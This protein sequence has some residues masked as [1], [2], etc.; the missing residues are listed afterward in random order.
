MQTMNNNSILDRTVQPAVNDIAMPGY[1]EYT[2]SVLP[3]G[4]Q[5]HSLKGGTQP[6]TKIDIVNKA[7][8]RFADK[9]CVASMVNALAAEGTQSYTSKQ[10]ADLFDF[11]AAYIGQKSDGVNSIM[12]VA[13]MTKHLHRVLPVLEEI[14]KCAAFNQHEFDTYV[15]KMLQEHAVNMQTPSIVARRNLRKLIYAPNSRFCRLA[16]EEAYRSLTTADMHAFY[17]KTYTPE[18]AHIFVSGQPTDEDI[19]L[20][21]QTFSDQWKPNANLGEPELPT[22]ND[23]PQRMFAEMPQ[24]HQV[25]ICMGRSIFTQDHEDSLPMSVLDTIFGG[26][27]G[28]RL[29]Q[30][31]RE[32]KGLTYGIG[33]NLN[34]T[35]HA[36]LHTIGSDVHPD[37]AEQVIEEIGNEMRKLRTELVSTEELD[38]VRNYMKGILLRQFDSVLAS[39]DTLANLIIKGRSSDRIRQLYDV[40]NSVT[41]QQLLE[42]AN[43][44]Y[45]PDLYSISMA[46][47]R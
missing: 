12:T 11:C 28:S 4:I 33:S 27:F 29:M 37:K 15:D 32:E 6:I 3:N 43:K 2:N 30:N 10:V 39:A 23:A 8:A 26:Y 22:Y 36:G 45:L 7:G 38:T 19:D 5:F 13:V 31:I 35:K 42:L 41:P 24:S 46:G 1:A 9:A 34:L 21:A 14:I 47:K 20:I 44:Y 18:G 25:S 40:I 16:T 17:D